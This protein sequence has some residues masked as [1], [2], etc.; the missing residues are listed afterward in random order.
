[1]QSKTRSSK[2]LWIGLG[3]V[4]V[5]IIAVMFLHNT[6]QSSES[7]SKVE[8]IKVGSGNDGQPFAYLDKDGKPA[9]MDIALLQAIDKKLPQYKF[10]L[11]LSDFPT[12]ITNLKSGKTTI[13]MYQIEQNAE[14]KE[15]FKF[16]TV[17]YTVWDTLLATK[18]STGVLDSFADAK[19]KKLYVTN[20]TNQA[21][22]TD[23]YL[24]KNANAYSVV[25]GTYTMEQVAQGLNSEQ[26]NV[27]PAPK[28]SIDL[29]N[30]QFKTN[31]VYGKSVNHSN[32]Y[33]MFNK[34][35]DPKFVKAVNKA[36]AEMKEDG[37]LKKL[38]NQWLKGDYVP[39]D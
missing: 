35:A 4:I 13:A 19:G 36:M 6:G 16:G 22:L 23:A 12:M 14:R 27:Y 37:T 3:V 24:K 28:Y 25:R 34:K 7:S 30:R 15:N 33:P 31:L 5:A 9:G 17:G 29:L 38:S 1:M 32:A 11:T 20:S 18:K 8:T 21:T 2:G 26:F 39:K 10:K